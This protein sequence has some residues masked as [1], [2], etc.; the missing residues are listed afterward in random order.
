MDLALFRFQSL[1]QGSGKIGARERDCSSR[2]LPGLG[3]RQAAHDVTGAD[4]RVR[5]G[6][7]QECAGI[8][9]RI[10]QDKFLDR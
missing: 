5:V 7:D 6:P 4:H 1:S 10:L 8:G 3:Q 9:G 2:V